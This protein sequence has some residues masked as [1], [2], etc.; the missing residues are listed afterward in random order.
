MG[1]PKLWRDV[2]KTCGVCGAKYAVTEATE[3]RG[4]G[5][6][7]SKPCRYQGQ[8]LRVNED[9]F[10][11]PTADMAYVLGLAITDGCIIERG[12]WGRQCDVL[13]IKSIDKDVLETTKRLMNSE[14]AIIDCGLTSK[15]NRVWRLDTPNAKIV[16]D[17]SRW[18]VVPRKTFSTKFPMD[19]PS[20]CHRDFVRGLLDGDGNVFC[21]NSKGKNGTTKMSVTIVGMRELLEPIPRL[22]GIEGHLSQHHNIYHLVVWKHLE[23]VRL[24]AHLYY[25]SNLP[26]MERKKLAYSEM[27]RTI[28]ECSVRPQYGHTKRL[29]V[30][31][32]INEVN[33]LACTHQSSLETLG[34]YQIDETRW[35][36]TP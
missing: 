20:E 28:S 7:C 21:G 3:R 18:G 5:K 25:R 34:S 16:E 2:E 19:L 14:Y 8:I 35:R 27:V 11:T 6:F 12:H 33:R 31:E 13:S 9:F 30:Q 15:G 23:L 4:R 22:L 17:I 24:H 26:C 10:A 29:A 36:G 1:R 32:A